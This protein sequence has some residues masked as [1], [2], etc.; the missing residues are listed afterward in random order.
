MNAGARGVT[1]V[2]PVKTGAKAGAGLGG[3]TAR[4]ECRGSG[5]AEGSR[6]GVTNY[7]RWTDL[8]TQRVS[9]EL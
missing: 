9:G 1:P 8:S 6:N 4:H 5:M 3:D 7:G 2:T